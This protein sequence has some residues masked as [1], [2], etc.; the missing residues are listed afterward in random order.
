M[1]VRLEFK[2]ED[3]WVGVY[4]RKG[5]LLR[6]RQSG[7]RKRELALPAALRTAAF[8][9][10]TPPSARKGRRWNGDNG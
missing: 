6:D 8:R 1:R 9:V 5:R 3:F 7:Q 2:L 4:W 10:E